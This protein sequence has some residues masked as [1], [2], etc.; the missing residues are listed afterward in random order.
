MNIKTAIAM[1]LALGVSA[2]AA[3]NV[4]VCVNPGTNTFPVVLVRAEAIASRMFATAGVVIEWH[5]AEP[6]VC[7]NPAETRTVILDF[8]TDTPRGVHPGAL[9]Y[10]K[11][12]EAI[13]IVVLYDRIATNSEGPGQVS[14]LLA[15]VMTHEITHLLEG[16]A[17]HSRTGVMKAN[18]DRND[19]RQMAFK[20]LPF[21]PE[22]IDLIQ[23]GL[24]QRAARLTPSAT[25]AVPP[26]TPMEQH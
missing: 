7:R 2:H 1:S 22:D 23:L 13:H 17:H 26:T 24:S 6:A 25:A 12:Y 10:A 15:H 9:A 5:T 8:D 16:F 20:S 11:P 19:M 4:R 3:A 18:W 14:A 21:D